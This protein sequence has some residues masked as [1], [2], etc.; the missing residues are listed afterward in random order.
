MGC[1]SASTTSCKLMFYRRWESFPAIAVESCCNL[2]R[3]GCNSLKSCPAAFNYLFEMK[4]LTDGEVG[5]IDRDFPLCLGTWTTVV[6]LLSKVKCFYIAFPMSAPSHKPVCIGYFIFYWKSSSSHSA[7]RLSHL[8]YHIDLLI[9]PSANYCPSRWLNNLYPH[10]SPFLCY[11]SLLNHIT[12]CVREYLSWA[13][14]FVPLKQTLPNQS[15]W[16][17]SH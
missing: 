8:L 11:T 13:L 7:P 15:R 12:L 16:K 5:N 6:M 3:W 9:C 1:V 10:T 2:S 4:K 14:G 17:L